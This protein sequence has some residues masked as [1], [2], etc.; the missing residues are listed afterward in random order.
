VR[1]PFA[2]IAS[3]FAKLESDPAFDGLTE[4]CPPV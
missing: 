2:F 1:G 3:S 4:E